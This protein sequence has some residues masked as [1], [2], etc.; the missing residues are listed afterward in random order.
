MRVLW[1]RIHVITNLE[2]TSVTRES[3]GSFAQQCSE[4]KTCSVWEIATHDL[5]LHKDNPFKLRSLSWKSKGIGPFGAKST[6]LGLQRC[7]RA[8]SGVSWRDTQFPREQGSSF[9]STWIVT[10]VTRLEMNPCAT[11]TLSCR[12]CNSAATTTLLKDY[13][14]LLLFSAKHP[15]SQGAIIGSL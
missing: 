8:V 4:W 10:F 5:T 14:R 7:V 11:S 13:I 12:Q 3:S 15:E 1:L 2:V 9:D 6:G